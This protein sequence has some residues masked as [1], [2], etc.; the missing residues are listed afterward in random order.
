MTSEVPQDADAAH[1]RWWVVGPLSSTPDGATHTLS[2][3]NFQRSFAAFADP[4]AVDIGDALGSAVPVE[5]TIRAEKL[6]DLTQRDII[7]SNP[8]LSEL[9]ELAHAFGGSVSQRPNP[10]EAIARVREQLG[11]GQLT[12][13]FAACFAPPSDT[14]A[15]V[16]GSAASSLDNILDSHR[17][18]VG[19]EAKQAVDSF[20]ST[21]R[22]AAPS[23]RISAGDS[24]AHRQA[25]DI[26]ERWVYAATRAAL[27]DP[28]T[29]RLESVW[30]GLRALVDECRPGTITVRLLNVASSGLIEALRAIPQDLADPME[31]PDAVFLWDEAPDVE[32]LDALA[33]IGADLNAPIVCEGSPRLFGDTTVEELVARALDENLDTS[34]DPGWLALRGREAARWLTLVINPVVAASEGTTAARRT[35]FASPVL[36][37]ASML[38][39]SFCY[40]GGFARIL[41]KTGGLKAPAV[42]DV[43]AGSSRITIPTRVFVPIRGQTQLATAGIIALGSGRNSDTVLTSAMPTARA[44]DDALPFAAQVLTGR[45]VRF[46]SWV[47]QQLPSAC[48]AAQLSQLFADAATVFLF[49]GMPENA[50]KLEAEVVDDGNSVR[51]IATVRPELAGIP[52]EVGFDMPLPHPISS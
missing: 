4:V 49:P 24:K 8:I 16:A 51:L 40:T 11:E 3:D 47:V 37:F 35:V 39:A 46:A 26:L 50:A 25:R 48:S 15:P 38:S 41:G 20:I 36:A 7:A 52:F 19:S 17:S 10:L 1:V 42:F 2:R 34:T 9:I 5:V 30:R 14:V 45:L 29:M 44:S 28:R 6:R 21:M 22:Q 31:G 43:T 12:A 18:D 23:S 27:A 33:E 32:Q 13:E